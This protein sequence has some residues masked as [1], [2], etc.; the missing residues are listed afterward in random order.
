MLVFAACAEYMPPI[1]E[2]RRHVNDKD[3]FAIGIECHLHPSFNIAV[4]ALAIIS[5][6]KALYFAGIMFCS[7]PNERYFIGIQ[8]RGNLPNWIITLIVCN[9]TLFVLFPGKY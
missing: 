5:I 2:W 4:V 3:A 1:E 6:V 8:F 9:K 7:F